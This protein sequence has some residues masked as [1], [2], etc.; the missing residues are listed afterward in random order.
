MDFTH[1]LENPDRL[2]VVVE[3]SDGTWHVSS[4]GTIVNIF[5]LR[6]SERALDKFSDILE[7]LGVDPDDSDDLA[8]TITQSVAIATPIL[9]G[10]DIAEQLQDVEWREPYRP[11]YDSYDSYSGYST[12]D[13]YYSDRKSVV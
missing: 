7:D 1:Q 12:A 5:S 11:S 13:Y 8:D 3:K 10:V 4:F 2:G 9:V 6:P